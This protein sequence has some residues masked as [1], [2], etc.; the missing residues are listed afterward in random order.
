MKKFI[1]FMMALLLIAATMMGC[2]MM[3]NVKPTPSPS[4]KPSANPT[5][6]PTASPLAT[7]SPVGT[8]G[9]GTGALGE[10]PN[11]MEGSVVDAE[12]V[13]EI[14]KAIEAKYAGASIQS[15][16]HET[17]LENQVYHIVLNGAAD[18]TTQV[19]VQPD[20]T[21]IPYENGTQTDSG[22]STETAKP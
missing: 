20:G 13:P 7:K 22:S 10:I 4:I 8:D 11:F 19:Y 5:V 21:I 18:G 1:P 16:T 12:D 14:V 17:Y 6:N 15:I 3:G 2:G 9:G